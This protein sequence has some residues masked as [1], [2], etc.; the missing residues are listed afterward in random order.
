MLSL[1]KHLPFKLFSTCLGLFLSLLLLELLLQIGGFF[2]YKYR[3]NNIFSDDKIIVFAGDSWTY[4]ADSEKGKS[5]FDLLEEDNDF[6][7]FSLVNVGYGGNNGFQVVNAIINHRKIPEIIIV[8]MGINNWH[9]MGLNEFIYNAENYLSTQEIIQL[10]KDLK[11][12]NRWIWL[13]RLKIYKLYHYFVNSSPKKDEI[14]LKAMDNKLG[15][16]LFWKMLINFREKYQDYNSAYKALPKLLQEA[17]GLSL[18]QKFYFV[19]LHLGFASEGAEDVLRK[20]GIFHPERLST[21]PYDIYRNIDITKKQLGDTRILFI[22]WAFKLLNKWALRNYVTVFVQT[23]P[24]IK[25]ENQGDNAFN[26]LNELIE[27]FARNN[28]FKIIDHNANGIDWV[29]YRTAWHVNNEG[30][31]LMKDIIKS[32]LLR[33][34]YFLELLRDAEIN[35]R[36]H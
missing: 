2:A 10:R 13:G 15:T 29:K 36:P 9:L 24:D 34:S 31:R 35:E 4:G 22:K 1:K 32:N 33:D 11:F 8:N 25:K 6:K 16:E 28:G 3:K 17:D 23:Y 20:A 27:V 19:A 12:Y 7:R 5:F 30:H 26:R 18:D 21:I 14:S